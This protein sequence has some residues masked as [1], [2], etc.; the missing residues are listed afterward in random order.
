MLTKIR[1]I[2]DVLKKA[3][4]NEDTLR[5]KLLRYEAHQY[6]MGVH[7]EGGE[8]QMLEKEPCLEELRYPLQR[9]LESSKDYTLEQY[10]ILFSVVDRA[11]QCRAL[12]LGAEEGMAMVGEMEEAGL[13]VNPPIAD[14]LADVLSNL[15]EDIEVD[16]EQEQKDRAAWAKKYLEKAEEIDALRRK[17]D[18]AEGW[19]T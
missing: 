5:R 11:S 2:R 7:P 4:A 8:Y 13:P 10:E 19:H 16:D 15:P 9:V 1:L 14:A 3:I 6:L 17:L 12:C 18:E